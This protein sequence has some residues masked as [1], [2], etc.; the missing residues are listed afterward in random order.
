MRDY[1]LGPYIEEKFVFVFTLSTVVWYYMVQSV[2]L[3]PCLSS[4]HNST[5]CV[6]DLGWQSKIVIFKYLLN[7]FVAN[8][9]FWGSWDNNKNWLEP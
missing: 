7:I 5:E 2:V 4:A 1:Y 6:T 8:V 9:I 3:G